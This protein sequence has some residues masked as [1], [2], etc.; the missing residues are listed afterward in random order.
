MVD[1]KVD[2]L[3]LKDGAETDAPETEGREG[4]LRDRWHRWKAQADVAET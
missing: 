1:N 3:E 4:G 2:L